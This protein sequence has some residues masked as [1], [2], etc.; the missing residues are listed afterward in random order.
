[1][2]ASKRF[3]I[4]VLVQQYIAIM[5]PFIHLSHLHIRLDMQM[6]LSIDLIQIDMYTIK[7]D[8]QIT[9]TDNL[10]LFVVSLE[11][12]EYNSMHSFGFMFG[13][14]FEVAVHGFRDLAVWIHIIMIFVLDQTLTYLLE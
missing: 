14:L 11:N 3:L 10:H 1:M 2:V 12:N 6:N 5:L 8:R 7:G 4:H 9:E 13:S